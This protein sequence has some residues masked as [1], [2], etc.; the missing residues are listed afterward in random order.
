MDF[1]KLEKYLQKTKQSNFRLRQIKQAYFQELKDNW[2]EIT[3][4]PKDLK[5]DLKEQFPSFLSVRLAKLQISKDGLTFKALLKLADHQTIETVLMRYRSWFTV[6]ISTQVGC[7]LGCKFCASGFCGFIRNLTPQEIVDQVVFWERAL[8]KEALKNFGSKNIKKRAVK[9]IVF[10]G[11]GEP[12]LNWKNVWAA[13]EILKDKDGLKIGERNMSISTIGLPQKIK[14]FTAKNSQINLAISLHTADEKLR[15][16]IMPAT[17]K[18]SLKSLMQAVKD[19]VKKT[20]RKVFFEYLL[21]NNL[22]DRKE[23]AQNLAKLFAGKEKYL[24]H[25]NL[26]SFNPTGCDF[27]PSSIEHI[28]EFTKELKKLGLT[29][30]LRKSFGQDIQAACGQLRIANS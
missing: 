5:I 19:Y 3:T 28:Q 26:I 30:T 11:M 29:Y 9:K 12:L 21:L 20:H 6:C 10:M 25:L 17:K 18:Y 27:R 7:P 23:D 1:K 15:Q 2:D 14:K 24:L 13:I 16:K 8:Q 4:L 22:T